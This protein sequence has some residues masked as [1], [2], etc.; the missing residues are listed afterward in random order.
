MISR[1]NASAEAE[2]RM[3]KEVEVEDIG[4]RSNIGMLLRDPQA[5]RWN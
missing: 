4:L 5:A 1:E 3:E 2:H